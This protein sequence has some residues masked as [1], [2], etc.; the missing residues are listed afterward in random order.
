MKNLYV[1]PDNLPV[2]IDDGACE[3]LEGS[4]L[5][6]VTLLSTSGRKVDLSSEPPKFNTKPLVFPRNQISP[7]LKTMT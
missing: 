5:P 4:M 6:A 7:L 2:P 1:L 3:H